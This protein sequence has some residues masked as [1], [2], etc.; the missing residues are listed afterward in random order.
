MIFFLNFKQLFAIFITKQLT[1]NL[2]ESVIPYMRSSLKQIKIID[3]AKKEA[4]RE[5]P[6]SEVKSN[7]EKLQRYAMNYLKNANI[8]L[9]SMEPLSDSDDVDQPEVESLMPTVRIFKLCR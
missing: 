3:K 6:N 1:G 9:D 8:Q 5:A 4:E 2:K 7:V